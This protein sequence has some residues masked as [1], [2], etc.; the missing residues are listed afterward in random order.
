MGLAHIIDSDSSERLIKAVDKALL[1]VGATSDNL[2]LTG[3]SVTLPYNE[4]D[5]YYELANVLDR[6]GYDEEY[7]EWLE[8]F[9]DADS[10]RDFD[11]SGWGENFWNEW[12]EY[13]GSDIWGEW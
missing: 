7:I 8:K 12:G 3:I 1:Y 11:W 5:L 2:S 10:D 13:E 9:C 4:P 6:S